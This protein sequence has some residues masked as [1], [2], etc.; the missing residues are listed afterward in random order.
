MSALNE[1]KMNT[2][3]INTNEQVEVTLPKKKVIVKKNK[4][5]VATKKVVIDDEVE[6]GKEVL[7][8][9]N[10]DVVEN[11]VVETAV[12][13]DL[14]ATAQKEYE[15]THKDIEE[16]F[17]E[18]DQ[19]AELLTEQLEYDLTTTTEEDKLAAM[20]RERAE[21]DLKIS[22][23][24]QSKMVR[25]LVVDYR[26]LL[27]KNRQEKMEV[28]ETKVKALQD[29]WDVLEKERDAITD[30]DDDE[31]TSTIMGDA[32]LRM[33][34]GFVPK[35]S[36]PEM[37]AKEKR[38]YDKKIYKKAP[39]TKKAD[40][41]PKTLT[42]ID[43]KLSWSLVPT[44]AVL[45]AAYKLKGVEFYVR[46]NSKGGLTEVPNIE[47]PKKRIKDMKEFTDITQAQKYFME[48]LCGL[49]ERT[50]NAWATFKAY[51]KVS[52]KKVSIEKINDNNVYD[53]VDVDNY[54]A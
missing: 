39:P 8:V 28:L 21:L 22:Q 33:E 14:F 24:E 45:V 50:G 12:V 32:K 49:V 17:E 4:T 20:L 43:R 26:A 44:N 52:K 27:L 5:P 29:E 25:R 1:T 37:N 9:T 13:E 10:P 48:E 23:Y 40:G 2:E 34:C 30:L 15:E 19:L 51:D 38:D 16:H 18:Q 6:E 31:L 35:S 41:Q 11:A 46:K 47:D 3:I 53:S 7:L 36:A 42:K 54:L